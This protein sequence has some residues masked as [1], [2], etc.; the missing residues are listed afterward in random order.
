MKTNNKK[1]IVIITSIIVFIL[2]NVITLLLAYHFSMTKQKQFDEN[3]VG[4]IYC[5]QI[6]EKHIG[7]TDGGIQ[8][9]DNEILIVTKDDV[10]KE[11]VEKL[12]KKYDAKIVGRIE[13]TGDYQLLLSKV[14]TLDELD[15]IAKDIE[16][17]K[18]VGSAYANYISVT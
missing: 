2:L 17:E 3:N 4:E 13:Q 8:Y 18:I 16:N 1:L 9:A 7:K 10:S 5:Q 15:Q 14:H 11:K 6:D 12:A